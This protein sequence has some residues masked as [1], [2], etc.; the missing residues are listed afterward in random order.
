MENA[1]HPNNCMLFSKTQYEC[2]EQ[3]NRNTNKFYSLIPVP[4]DINKEMEWTP[5]Y[6]LTN[7]EFKFLPTC[8]C[9]AQYP[10]ANE[11]DQY[12]YPDSNGCAAGNTLEEAILQGFLELIERDAAAI[13]WYNRIERPALNLKSTH[14]E[15]I[16]RMQEYY[17]EINRSLYVLDITTDLGIPVF[18]AVSHSLKSNGYI[19]YAFGAH[20]DANIAVE[21]A[22]VELNQLLPVFGSDGNYITK[23]QVFINWLDSATIE[24]NIY[25]QPLSNQEKSLEYD[26]L[27]LCKP[28]IYHSLQF[29]IETAKKHGIETLVLDVTQPDIGLPVVK[30]IAPGLRHFW[31]R[32]AP[33]RLYDVPA[34]LG[35]LNKANT[36]EELNPLS[37]F[38]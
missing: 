1:I 34:K 3:V 4:F 28:N 36:E 5:V 38:I 37:I 35:W 17:R 8:Y 6:S 19:I 33:G 11:K 15:Y 32:T 27:P 7:K 31:R 18:A 12:S 9:Y 22:I 14:N 21:R 26:F 20:I 16:F 10:T 30:V 24:D 29:C 25:L 23:D 13:W 2:R